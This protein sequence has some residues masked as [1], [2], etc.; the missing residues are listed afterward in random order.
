MQQLLNLCIDSRAHFMYLAGIWWTNADRECAGIWWRDTSDRRTSAML[1]AINCGT[2]ECVPPSNI[3]NSD[4]PEL[5]NC[6]CRTIAMHNL[7]KTIS[8]TVTSRTS[9]TL[10]QDLAYWLI[11]PFIAYYSYKPATTYKNNQM[12]DNVI[13]ERVYHRDTKQI[14]NNN[15][16]YINV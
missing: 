6:S 8:H 15:A 5:P 16:Q 7:Y 11:N 4:S 10:T 3:P 14:Q 2:S 12:Q 13:M 1:S 9:F